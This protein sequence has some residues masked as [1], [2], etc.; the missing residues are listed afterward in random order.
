MFSRTAGARGRSSSNGPP[1]AIL[2]RKKVRVMIANK[3]GI[4]VKIR[5]KA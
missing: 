4:I 1:G 2:I 3:V 5:L